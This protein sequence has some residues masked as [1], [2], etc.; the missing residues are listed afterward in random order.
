M[1]RSFIYLVIGVLTFYLGVMANT[2]FVAGHVKTSRLARTSLVQTPA[3]LGEVFSDF[4]LVGDYPASS[5]FASPRDESIPQHPRNESLPL[6]QELE[7]HR[8]YIFRARSNFSGDETYEVLK[9]RLEK[10]GI[11]TAFGM[12]RTATGIVTVLPLPGEPPDYLDRPVGLMFRFQNLEG[13]V[14]RIPHEHTSTNR[15][16]NEEGYDYILHVRPQYAL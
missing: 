14:M 2:L 5:A 4:D 6:P 7:L 8:R 12:P 3:W 15:N 16:S 9:G 10:A 13:C 1:R 11:F